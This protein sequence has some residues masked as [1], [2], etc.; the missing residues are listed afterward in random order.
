MW[1]FPSTRIEVPRDGETVQTDRLCTS[2][3]LN[4]L[5]VYYAKDCLLSQSKHVKEP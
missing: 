4:V 5:I 3:H 2:I 1:M